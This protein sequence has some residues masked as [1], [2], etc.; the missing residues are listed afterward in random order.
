M[1]LG[2]VLFVCWVDT[3]ISVGVVLAATFGT[4]G[5]VVSDGFVG[6][7]PWS[8]NI[9]FLKVGPTVATPAVRTGAVVAEVVFTGIWVSFVGAYSASRDGGVGCDELE[10]GLLSAAATGANGLVCVEVGILGCSWD[11]IACAG[12]GVA[13]GERVFPAV[14][15]VTG[16]SSSEGATVCGAVGDAN[17]GASMFGELARAGAVDVRSVAV[18][19]DWIPASIGSAFWGC[20][21][22]IVARPW[23]SRKHKDD[24]R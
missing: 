6:V 3:E 4:V 9:A 14:R 11:M 10:D 17:V 5:T 16:T 21:S 19:I 22:G 15:V 24:V 20:D 1:M 18:V 7:G 13:D 23:A 2:C 12:V 8:W